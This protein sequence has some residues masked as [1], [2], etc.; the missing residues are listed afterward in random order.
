MRSL[1][2]T[3]NSEDM[4]ALLEMMF[5]WLN[6]G[7]ISLSH[8][9]LVALFVTLRKYFLSVPSLLARSLFRFSS[10]S[11]AATSAFTLDGNSV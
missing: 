4:H 3:A 8:V 5:S 1:S 6:E 2:L 9:S 11:L 7:T 10:F